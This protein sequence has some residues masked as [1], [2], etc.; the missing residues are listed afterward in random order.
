MRPQVG[1]LMQLLTLVFSLTFLLQA[2]PDA[3]SSWGTLIQYLT[4]GFRTN[5]DKLRAIFV[6]LGVHAFSHVDPQTVGEGDDSPI[7]EIKKIQEKKRSYALLFVKICRYVVL[8]DTG[9]EECK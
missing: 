6:W 9:K 8:P 7:G 2:P 1:T 3:S 4:W 5:M